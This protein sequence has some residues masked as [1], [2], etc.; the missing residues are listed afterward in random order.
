M[1]GTWSVAIGSATLVFLAARAVAGATLEPHAE[2]RGTEVAEVSVRAAEGGWHAAAWDDLDRT[3]IDPGLYQVRLQVDGDRGGGSFQVPICAGRERVTIDGRDVP[4]P[5]GPLLVPLSPGRHD[6][7]IGVTVSPYERR[8]AC[9]DHPRYGTAVSTLEGLGVVTFA[10]PWSARGGGRAVLYVPPHHDLHTPSPLLVG[11]HPWNGSM[12]TYAAYA[13]LLRAARARDV[14]LLMPSGLGNSLYTADAEDEVMR[15]VA[16]VSDALA[17]DARAVSLWGASMGGAGATT[18]GFHHPDRFAGITSFFGDSKYD[19]STYVRSILP[20]S[21]AAHLVNALDVV[22]NARDLPVWLIHGE[23]DRT[24]PIRQ[25]EMLASKLQEQGGRVRF[26]RIPGMGHSGAL[27][28]RFL[29]EVVAAAASARV[30][31]RV[32]RVTYRS[33][34]AS[35]TQAYGVRIIRAKEDGDA[36]VDVERRADAVH[37][38]RAEGVRALVLS[39]GSLGASEPPPPIVIDDGHARD[40]DARWAP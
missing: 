34:R 10:S 8:I 20:N 33:V 26:D 13:P 28:S 21:A 35:D 31:D 37:V 12:W 39:R 36:V 40:L 3:P 27:V 9:G 16:A 18:I 1:R 23:D 25:S 29:P 4:A 22:D 19:L 14:P 24:S 2:V 30:P 6:I 38:L 17:V 5:P 15:A 7:L 32:T 11:L